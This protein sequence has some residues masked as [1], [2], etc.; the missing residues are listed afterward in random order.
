MN[1]FAVLR[2]RSDRRRAHAD[3]LRLDDH[4][5]SDI[6]ITRAEIRRLPVRSGF[7]S[8]E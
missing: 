3:L 8:H 2:Q 4:L 7:R 5:L 1:L 6:G